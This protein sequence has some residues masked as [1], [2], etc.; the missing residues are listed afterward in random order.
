MSDGWRGDESKLGQ[1]NNGG[2]SYKK[3]RLLG[4]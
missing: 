3:V 2:A 4:A 1:R